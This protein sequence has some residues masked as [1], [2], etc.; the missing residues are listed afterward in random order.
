MIG[1]EETFAFRFIPAL[2]HPSMGRAMSLVTLA[3]FL[4]PANNW[5]F[6]KINEVGT[7]VK[8]SKE[9]SDITGDYWTISLPKTRIHTLEQLIAHCKIDLM[10]WEVERFICNKWDVGMS[11]PEPTIL[12]LFQV[13]AFLRKKTDVVDA[14]NE[15]NELRKKADKFSP[16]YPALK[17][18]KESE[19]LAEFS[20][21]DH[22]FGALIWGRET[23][24][25]DYDLKIAKAC[26]ED[27]LTA[28][29]SRTEGYK[30]D[31]ALLVL[32]NDQQNA[33]N[34]AGTTE[35]GTMQNMDSRYQKVFSVSRDCS[36]WAIDALLGQYKSVDVVL[37]AGNH[38]PLSAWHLGDSLGSWY[39]NCSAVKVNNEPS[40]RKYYEY[41][42]NML[43]FTHGHAGKIEDYGKT[44]A[45]EQPEMW[46]RTKWREAHTGDKHHR[47][48]IEFPGVTIRILPSLRPPD[49]WSSEYNYVGSIRS[50]EAYVW[51]K[52][53]GLIGTSVYSILNKIT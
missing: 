1:H 21:N 11:K 23:G 29:V 33:D 12:E 36:I 5:R 51:N 48:T 35:R 31:K 17:R 52:E 47:R 18:T 26:W 41:G 8:A 25:E 16:K 39:R 7:T 6:M 38:D 30:P 42:T 50:A 45:A 4:L 40:F 43:L 24:G 32:G 9:T 14:L 53:E 22:H 2:L 15:L 27:A 44:M 19:T 46:G 3:L 28:L 49:A 13:K 10:I 34:R 20:I 37:V